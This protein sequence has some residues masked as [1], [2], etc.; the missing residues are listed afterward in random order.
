MRLLGLVRFAIRCLLRHRTLCLS[1]GRRRK[2]SNGGRDGLGTVAV[3]QDFPGTFVIHEEL[4]L[5]LR[6]AAETLGD[7]V[8]SLL[9]RQLVESLYLPKRGGNAKTDFL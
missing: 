3:A 9:I 7:V 5:A 6:T 2:L 1:G 8:D 4:C